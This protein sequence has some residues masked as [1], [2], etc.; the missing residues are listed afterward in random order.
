MDWSNSLLHSLLVVQVFLITSSNGLCSSSKPTTSEQ[1]ASHSTE[2]NFIP[3]LPLSRRDLLISAGAA[4][5][6]ALHPSLINAIESS[7]AATTSCLSDLPPI[8]SPAFTTRVFFCRHGETENNRLGKIQGARIDPPLNPTGI[9]QAQ[10]LG[11]ALAAVRPDRFVHS[12]LQRAQETATIAAAACPAPIS[13][14]ADLKEIDFGAALEGGSST[15]GVYRAQITATYAAWAAGQWETRLG[16]NGETGQEVLDRVQ[17]AI[18][19]ILN[20]NRGNDRYIAAVAHSSYLRVLLS[21][22][23]GVSMAEAATWKIRNCSI[24][25]VDFNRETKAAKLIRIGE[26]RHLVSAA[27]AQEP[28]S[29]ASMK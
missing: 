14:I 7:P 6:L 9:R 26:D 12:P 23:G 4:A 17:R 11:A 27:V 24:H 29:V 15:A 25:V 18:D 2:S 8:E 22:A 3:R 20:G 16:A 1:V 10:A 21:Y 19:A 28:A 5:P 13:T